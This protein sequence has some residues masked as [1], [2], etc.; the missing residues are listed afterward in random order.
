MLAKR[1]NTH[2][3]NK[4]QRCW[5]GR[6]SSHEAYSEQEATDHV[7]MGGLEDPCPPETRRRVKDAYFDC[8]SDDILEFG[9]STEDD[10]GPEIDRSVEIREVDT[11]IGKN[12]KD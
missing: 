10:P 4:T 7:S 6:N 2:D 1:R 3:K 8:A 11:P 9:M 12:R 5:W